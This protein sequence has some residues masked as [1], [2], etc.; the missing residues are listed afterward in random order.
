MPLAKILRVPRSSVLLVGSVLLAPAALAPAALADEPKRVFGTH[1]CNR[2]LMVGSERA[3]DGSFAKGDLATG[4]IA[5]S[6]A[7]AD[8]SCV[9]WTLGRAP[10]NVAVSWANPRDGARYTVTPIRTYEAPNGDRC[11]DYVAVLTSGKRRIAAQHS[12]CR[13][14]SGAWRLGSPYADP[15]PRMPDRPWD[16]WSGEP[17]EW[18]EREASPG[19]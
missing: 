16:R 19:M 12:A 18:P 6:M 17:P 7:R 13:D 10:S 9:G 3:H 8:H 2:T 5:R 4:E 15:P 11:R 14:A 1:E